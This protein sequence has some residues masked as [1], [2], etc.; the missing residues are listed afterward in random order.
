[1]KSFVGELTTKGIVTKDYSWFKMDDTNR[2]ISEDAIENLEDDF[3]SNCF[4]DEYP[5]QSPVVV[6]WVEGMENGV[7]QQGHHRFTVCV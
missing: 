2:K 7:I 4:N 1:M 5:F 6:Y 3:N